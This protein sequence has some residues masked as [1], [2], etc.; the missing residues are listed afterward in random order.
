MRVELVEEAAASAEAM[1]EQAGSLMK[2]VSVFKLETGKAGTRKT[3]AKPA[4]APPAA[5]PV[6]SL[7]KE[8]KLIKDKEDTDGDWKEF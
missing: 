2:A 4:I 3:V 5:S 8:R 1:Q 7:R 6:A